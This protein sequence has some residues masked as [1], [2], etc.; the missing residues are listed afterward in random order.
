MPEQ[1]KVYPEPAEPADED[2][3]SISIRTGSDVPAEEQAREAR[4]KG[5]A[6]EPAA[7]H[8]PDPPLPWHKVT[9]PQ[10]LVRSPKIF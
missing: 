7:P 4:K 6:D 2:A 3:V 9:P 5:T 8:A 1:Q 10:E